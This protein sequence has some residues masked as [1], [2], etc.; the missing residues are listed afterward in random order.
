MNIYIRI[1]TIELQRTDFLTDVSHRLRNNR[2][3][4]QKTELEFSTNRMNGEYRKNKCARKIITLLYVSVKINALA[5]A[6]YIVQ[7]KRP[8]ETWRSN[9]E[10]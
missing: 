9:I 6:M 2:E 5:N 10:I 3:K 7:N 8:D 1:K 4:P